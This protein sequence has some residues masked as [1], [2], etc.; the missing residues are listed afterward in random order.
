MLRRLTI[1]NYALIDSTVVEFDNG[2]TVITGETG[3]GKSI[4]LD[5]LGLL[6]GAR[7]DL[8]AMGD[9][10]R[11]TYVEGVFEKPGNAVRQICEENDIDWDDEEIIIRRE[12]SPA[13]KSRGFVNDTPVNLTILNELSAQLIDIHSQHSNSSLNDSKEQ[14]D[15]IDIYG[16]NQELLSEYQKTFKS[17]VALRGKIKKIKE[18]QAQSKENRDYILFRLEQLDKLKPKAG[19]LEALEKE[20]ELLSNADRLKTGLGEAY[21]IIDSDSDSVVHLLNR[22]A[23]ALQG[24]DFSLFQVSEEEDITRRLESLKI[25]LRD[26]AD[27]INDCMEKVDSNPVRYEE[28]KDRMERI[29]E[30]IKRFKVRD[31]A[32]LVALYEDLKKELNLMEGDGTDLTESE[33]ELK[34]LAQKLKQQA[35]SLTQGRI[36]SIESFSKN[37]VE[38]LQPLG[39]PNIR[40]EVDLQKGKLTADGQDR[41]TFKCSFNKNHPMQ[42]VAEIASG[43]EVARVMLGIKSIMA[44]KINLPTVIFD[45]I[46]TG[47][48]GEIAH[49]M[50]LTMKKMAENMQVVAVTHLPQVAASG[51]THF[52]VYKMDDAEKTVSHIK[53]LKGEERVEEIA[54]MLSGMKINEAAVSNARTLLE[55]E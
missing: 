55:T 14:T 32:E 22:A 26:I 4:M 52:K 18:A 37:L 47:V 7:A 6:M 25:D 9:K 53:K 11:K 50:G 43:G 12:I 20:F 42:P 38:R 46:D 33:K 15:I 13:G 21:N 17:Y 44:E 28:V 10:T 31:E 40:F 41:I 36:K 27:T 19:E 49:K 1:E 2:F 23:S 16:D 39:M 29:Y 8:K 24:I 34:L 35:D 51:T 5:A 45:E 48:S 54:G 30:A 3:A